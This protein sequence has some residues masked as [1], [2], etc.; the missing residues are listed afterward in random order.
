MAQRGSE[1]MWWRRCRNRSGGGEVLEETWGKEFRGE[2][3]L[4]EVWGGDELGQHS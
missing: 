2:Y 3:V 4:E 1:E